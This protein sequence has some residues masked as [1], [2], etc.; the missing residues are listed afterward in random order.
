MLI[1]V[2][3]TMV[4]NV[5]IVPDLLAA[6]ALSGCDTVAPDHGTGKITVVKKLSEGAQ[7]NAVGND[8]ADIAMAIEQLTLFIIDCYGFRLTSMSDCRI[9][10]WIQGKKKRTAFE[11][12]H[13]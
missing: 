11:I 10:S 8:S 4:E 6:P 3:N 2:V 9:Q 7:L 12:F 13:P 1:N 5:E